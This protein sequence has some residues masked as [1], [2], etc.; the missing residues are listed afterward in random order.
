MSDEELFGLQEFRRRK[1]IE[2]I[3]R[4]AKNIGGVFVEA[5]DGNANLVVE[6]EGALWMLA[7]KLPERLGFQGVEPCAGQIRPSVL[8]EREIPRRH[9]GTETQDGRR[10]LIHLLR[11]PPCLCASVVKYSYRWA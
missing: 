11:A 7:G 6:M 9:G 3:G 5:C 2:E 1:H 8:L 4:F 10:A